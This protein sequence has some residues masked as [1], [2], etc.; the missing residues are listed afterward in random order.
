[1]Q[2]ILTPINTHPGVNTIFN[3]FPSNPIS[4]YPSSIFEFKAKGLKQD[5]SINNS[6]YKHNNNIISMDI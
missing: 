2:N 6:A 1:M 5:D 4:L 3:A